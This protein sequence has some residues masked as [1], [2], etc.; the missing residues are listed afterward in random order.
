VTSN[1]V[2]VEW[3]EKGKGCGYDNDIDA[4]YHSHGRH[5]PHSATNTTSSTQRTTAAPGM[6][7]MPTSRVMSSAQ[8]GSSKTA[9]GANG[10]TGNNQGAMTV[11]R[12]MSPTTGR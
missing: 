12:L 10:S 11:T 9:T 8:K 2:E 5:V 4:P 7:T 6:G 3:I 1:T